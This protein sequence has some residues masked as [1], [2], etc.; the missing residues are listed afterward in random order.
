MTDTKNNKVKGNKKK[1]RKRKRV[2][3]DRYSTTS[4]V[5][6]TR[7]ARI[8]VFVAVITIRLARTHFSVVAQTPC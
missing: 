8:G 2:P 6:S 5:F 7:R 4:I 3:I 1:E